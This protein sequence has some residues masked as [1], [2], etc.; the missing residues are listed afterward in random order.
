MSARV[1]KL[2]SGLTVV[3]DRMDHLRTASLGIWVGA[4]SRNEA[5]D[6]HGIAAAR[7]R[8]SKRSRRSAAT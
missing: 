5:E 3:T 4:G 8:S 1:E 2:P 7:V 6:E